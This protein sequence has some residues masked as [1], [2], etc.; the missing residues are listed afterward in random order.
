MR[1]PSLTASYRV[2]RTSPK[3]YSQ[4]IDTTG[5]SCKYDRTSQ[6][7]WLR[8]SAPFLLRLVH[9]CRRHSR[10]H[11]RHFRLFQHV[12]HFS[13]TDHRRAWR[14]SRRIFADSY[15]RDR[16]RR[17]DRAHARF[18][19]R[20]PW[21]AWRARL[22]RAHGRRGAVTF[23]L[24]AEFLAVR[25]RALLVGHRRRSTARL[26]GDQRHHRPMVRAQARP[27]HG[28]RQPRHRCRQAE[29]PD[30]RRVAVRAR[31]LALHLGDLRHHRA[32]V[33]CRPGADFRA[34]PTRGLR[35][36]PRWRSTPG[37]HCRA[38]RIQNRRPPKTTGTKF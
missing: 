32:A 23:E 34:P 25:R 10:Q 28:H 3:R 4:S 7:G 24:G 9:R 29:Y 37:R 36:P 15:F 20:P 21:W 13:Q 31:R 14:N 11:R 19:D 1:F 33:S 30:R 2:R 5:V 38:A 17:V 8:H 12:E 16:R 26:P 35:T 18:V 22:G 6:D 27:R